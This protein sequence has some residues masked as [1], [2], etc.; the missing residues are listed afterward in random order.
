MEQISPNHQT[1]PNMQTTFEQ[2]APVDVNPPI[3]ASA[4]SIPVLPAVSANRER[5][6]K[7]AYPVFAGVPTAIIILFSFDFGETYRTVLD[8]V[9][10]PIITGVTS[11]FILYILGLKR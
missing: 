4:S 7:V 2:P 10:S 3:Q 9:L 11:G 1:Q 5:F 8:K 6:M